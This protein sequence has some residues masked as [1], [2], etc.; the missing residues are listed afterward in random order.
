MKFDA[1]MV[2]CDATL[3]QIKTSSLEREYFTENGL[4][5]RLVK[6]FETPAGASRHTTDSNPRRISLIRELKRCLRALENDISADIHDAAQEMSADGN[7]MSSASVMGGRFV[8][9]VA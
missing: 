5:S 4:I 2:I 3:G 6:I 7:L 1:D 9:T 8:V